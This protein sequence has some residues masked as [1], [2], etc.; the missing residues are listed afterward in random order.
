M[1][2]IN[3]KHG[4]ARVDKD[5]SEKTTQALEQM[6][7]LAF[8]QFQKIDVHHYSGPIPYGNCNICGKQEWE[9]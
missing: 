3:M 9:H 2:R 7:D 4:T 5:I 1:K 8:S 6:C